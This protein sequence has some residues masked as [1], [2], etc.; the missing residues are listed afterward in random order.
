MKMKRKGFR[1]TRK[2]NVL[3]KLH[4][5]DTLISIRAQW[6]ET[7]KCIEWTA[8]G[9]ALANGP[10][11]NGTFAKLSNYQEFDLK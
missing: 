10:F 1:A 8:M 5:H 11:A 9:L 7:C 4:M 2:T 6:K 3:H